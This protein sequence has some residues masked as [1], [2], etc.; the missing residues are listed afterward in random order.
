MYD[1]MYILLYSFAESY[2]QAYTPLDTVDK[3]YYYKTLNY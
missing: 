1:S 2:C 3:G